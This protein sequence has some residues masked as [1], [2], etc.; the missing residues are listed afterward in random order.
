MQFLL[1]LPEPIITYDLYDRILATESL[2]LSISHLSS[3]I[4]HLSSFDPSFL[5]RRSLQQH[6]NPDES[7]E[8]T[9]ERVAKVTL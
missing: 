5:T 2:F 9:S 8:R 4:S 1:R 3:L 7:D 6:R